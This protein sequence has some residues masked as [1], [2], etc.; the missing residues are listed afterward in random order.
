MMIYYTIFDHRNQT[1]VVL[2]DQHGSELAF[3][4]RLSLATD[5]NT[6]AQF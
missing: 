4:S 5:V 2:N 3:A 1:M 6:T